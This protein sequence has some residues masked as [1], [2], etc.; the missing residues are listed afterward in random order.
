MAA[1]AQPPPSPA[2]PGPQGLSPECLHPA[3]GPGQAL[4][5]HTQAPLTEPVL[6]QTELGQAGGCPQGLREIKADGVGQ[7]AAGQS[8]VKKHMG[9]SA[10]ASATSLYSSCANCPLPGGP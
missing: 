1:V 3:L 10:G 2:P 7:F 6:E 4:A 9:L 8:V 5:Q